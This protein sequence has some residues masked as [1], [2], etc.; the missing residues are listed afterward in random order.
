[1]RL[2][3]TEGAIGARP[4]AEA[5]V[6]GPGVS[7]AEPAQAAEDDSRGGS[8]VTLVEVDE[9]I[10]LPMTRLLRSLGFAVHPCRTWT[11]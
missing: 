7:D 11:S 4:C 9:A 3:E 8:R 1:M 2:P 10:L 5:G 6:A